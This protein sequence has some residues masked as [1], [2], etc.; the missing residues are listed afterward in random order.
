MKDTQDGFLFESEIADQMGQLMLEAV[1]RL[2]VV[3]DL[4]PGSQAKWSFEL[5]GITFQACISVLPSSE[6]E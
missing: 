2:K 6:P 1:D 5:D 4:C 3:D